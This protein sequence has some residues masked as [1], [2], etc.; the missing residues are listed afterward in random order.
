MVFV[1]VTQFSG[2]VQ[3]LLSDGFE[4]IRAIAITRGR[5]AIRV[6]QNAEDGAIAGMASASKDTRFGTVEGVV[7][8]DGML[9]SSLT[10]EM[11]R[12]KGLG[13][14]VDSAIG[15]HAVMPIAGLELMYQHE[16]FTSSVSASPAQGLVCS[17]SSGVEPFMVGGAAL[18]QPDGS[19]STL[20]GAT[21]GGALNAI[22]TMPHG[23]PP[24]LHGSLMVQ[25]LPQMAVCAMVEKTQGTAATTAFGAAYSFEEYGLTAKAMVANATMDGPS[26]SVPMSLSKAAIMKS[27]GRVQL[28]LAVEKPLTLSAGA[29]ALPP[30]FGFM[31]GISLDA[32]SPI[33]APTPSPL[34]SPSPAESD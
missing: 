6:M 31:L 24:M 25:P 10:C 23:S 19:R 7:T 12:V 9:C 16:A 28:G 3:S 20:V 18:L 26:G 1:P 2:A 4:P 21:M 8:G 17:A 15:V 14:R 27:F 11:E 33:D 13:L 5:K 29:P 22:L 34:D 32:P 30:K